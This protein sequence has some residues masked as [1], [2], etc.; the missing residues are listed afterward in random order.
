MVRRFGTGRL[1]PPNDR[2]V[3]ILDFGLAYF[4]YLSPVISF[5]LRNTLELLGTEQ[6]LYTKLFRRDRLAGGRKRGNRQ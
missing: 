3:A 1:L 6:P 5:S 2:A 4:Q